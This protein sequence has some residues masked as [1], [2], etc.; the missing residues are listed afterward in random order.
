MPYNIRRFRDDAG[1]SKSYLL[2]RLAR[3]ERDGSM[4]WRDILVGI[5]HL[6]MLALKICLAVDAFAL[7]LP[8]LIWL[9]GGLPQG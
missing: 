3:M 7:V 4:N 5:G 1:T 2:R 6:G 9:F 8:V